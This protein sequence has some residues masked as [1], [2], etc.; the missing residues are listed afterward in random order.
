MPCLSTENSEIASEPEGEASRHRQCNDFDFSLS[1]SMHSIALKERFC[2]EQLKL[3]GLVVRIGHSW[4]CHSRKHSEVSFLCMVDL[5]IILKE[6]YELNSPRPPRTA[7]WSRASHTVWDWGC[8]DLP[9]RHWPSFLKHLCLFSR[10]RGNIW[11]FPTQPQNILLFLHCLESH[12]LLLT[13]FCACV[14]CMCSW[15]TE[16]AH[17]PG[18]A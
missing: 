1:E 8:W 16:G 7:M 4:K 6:K 3:T 2:C 11:V 13:R 9:W 17:M 5:R 18:H 14:L 15:V 12:Q 10:M